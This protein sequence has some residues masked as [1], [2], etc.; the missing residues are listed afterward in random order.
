[1]PPAMAAE[2]RITPP[3]RVKIS[4]A[5][6]MAC[7]VGMVGSNDLPHYTTHAGSDQAGAFHSHVFSFTAR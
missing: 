5:V 2:V 7:S 1:M 3:F 4:V 6:D